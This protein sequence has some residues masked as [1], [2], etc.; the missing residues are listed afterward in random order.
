M[1]EGEMMKRIIL[2]IMMFLL[3]GCNQE[4]EENTSIPVDEPLDLFETCLGTWIYSDE[5]VSVIHMY[6]DGTFATNDMSLFDLEEVYGD[7]TLVGE[8]SLEGNQVKFN[9]KSHFSSAG[10]EE[11]IASSD[12]VIQGD[13][14]MLS[15][16]SFEKNNDFSTVGIAEDFNGWWQRTN[17]HQADTGYVNIEKVKDNFIYFEAELYSGGNMGMIT[18]LA[19]FISENKAVYIHDKKDDSLETIEFTIRDEG[20]EIVCT[21][22]ISNEFGM[23]VFMEGL[24]T[25]DEPTYTNAN[26]M[27]DTFKT[28]E[29]IKILEELLGEE[30]FAFLDLVMN[31]AYKSLDDDLSFSGFVRG[32]GYGVNILMTEDNYIYCLTYGQEDK[33]VYYTNDPKGKDLMHPYLMDKVRD[34]SNIRFVYN[35]HS[36]Y[37]NYDDYVWIRGSY[38]KP[39]SWDDSITWERDVGEYVEVIVSDEIYDFQIVSLDFDDDF[40]LVYGE[41]IYEL[42]V[43]NQTFAMNTYHPEGIPS[44]AIVFK[45]KYGKEHSFVISE[46]TLRGELFDLNETIIPLD[47]HDHY[48]LVKTYEGDFIQVPYLKYIG[49]SVESYV[50][51]GWLLLDS[52][53]L[54]FNGDGIM[55]IVGVIE[56]DYSDKEYESWD[57]PR[58]LF[59]LKGSSSGYILDFQDINLVRHAREGGVF[60]DPYLP[61]TTDDKDFE[62]HTFGGS[63]WKWSESSRFTYKDDTWY[64]KSMLNTYGYGPYVTD[65]SL[66]DY[67]IGV[68]VRQ[69]NSENLEDIDEQKIDFDLSFEVSLSE[70]PSLRSVS[71]EWW[72]AVDRLGQLHLSDVYIP[73]D[74]TPI[75]ND[76]LLR[77]INDRYKIKDM[78]KDYIIF[79]V[80]SDERKKEHLLKYH[81][82]FGSLTMILEADKTSAFYEVFD[83][84]QLCEDGL[85]YVKNHIVESEDNSYIEKATIHR[86][87]NYG[88]KEELASFENPPVDGEYPYFAIYFEL[89]NEELLC[90]VYGHE[91][92]KYYKLSYDDYKL[93]YIGEVN[94]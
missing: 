59:A 73:E 67:E 56:K 91:T 54:D 2:I 24:Y 84:V 31:S 62:I 28:A 66:D 17:V 3:I 37:M 69:K 4:S 80:K 48:R 33:E 19:S 16:Q 51:F 70:M 45:D 34:F 90:S 38:V 32:V 20:L 25:L 26:I 12:G 86:I 36:D 76:E 5:K 23:G 50:P 82:R 13:Y 81:K 72:L 47:Y 83:Q 46:R 40:H 77:I 55:D 44:E 64:L 35:D 1:I 68:G 27:M 29:R 7:S 6:A 65:Y 14:L 42:D 71:E 93:N 15:N 30:G 94:N 22:G 41:P 21:P 88:V 18:G 11:L 49:D 43:L 61:L 10:L 74:M 92:T 78:N 85:Y 57:Y 58:I 9:T 53:D 87:D 79:S 63:A 52:V 8:W 39:N 89:L 60:G 75:E